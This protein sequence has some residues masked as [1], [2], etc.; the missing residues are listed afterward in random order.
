MKPR[1]CIIAAVALM[2]VFPLSALLAQENA[3]LAPEASVD[4]VGYFT[5]QVPATP[6]E[7]TGG[8]DEIARDEVAEPAAVETLPFVADVVPAVAE[9]EDSSDPEEFEV[10]RA[11]AQSDA[12]DF[13]ES[14]GV[15]ET[16]PIDSSDS[17]IEPPAEENADSQNVF[18][19]DREAPP[20][21]EN[22]QTA[23][24]KRSFW[25]R[26]FGSKA[27]KPAQEEPEAVVTDAAAEEQPED[28]EVVDAAEAEP[29]PQQI[30]AMQE[31]VRRQAAEIQAMRSFKQADQAMERDDYSVALTHLNMGMSVMPVRPQTL[32]IR[33]NARKKQ[34]DCAYRMALNYYKE[35]L[36]VEAKDSINRAN[37]YYPAD[38]RASKLGERIAREEAKQDPGV[39]PPK[40]VGKTD[41]FVGKH[42]RIKAAIKR[43]RQ[44]MEVKEYEKAK[45]E[46]R[47]VLA[48]DS[49]N[50]DAIANLKKISEWEY[51]V[52]TKM[53]EATEKD[54]ITQ[55]RA[56]WT[57]PL[58]QEIAPPQLEPEGTTIIPPRRRRL[59]DKLNSIVIPQLDFRQAN[60]VDVV[61]YLVQQSIAGDSKSALTERGVNLILN[62]KRPG[63]SETF[64]AAPARSANAD[65]FAEEAAPSAPLALGVPSVT[66]SL[67]NIL[68]VDAIK[69]ITEV[70]GL[71]Y[72][73]EDDVVVITPADVVVG[74]VITRTY[75]VQPTIQ[76]V[77]MSSAPSGEGAGF[78][79]LGAA[80]TTERADVKSFFVEAGVA[81]P[82]GTSIMYKQ[83]IN[84]LIVSNTEE[85][86]ERVEHILAMLDVIPTQ[87]EIEARFV[88]IGQK[89]LMELGVEWQLTDNWQI[90][91]EVG[92]GA[93]V[94]LSSRERIQVNKNDLGKGM[95]FLASD[96][97]G[98]QKGGDLSSI[99]SISSILTNPEMTFILHALE[100]K[101]GV[102]LLSAPKVTTKSGANAEIKVVKELIYPT[103]FNIETADVTSGYTGIT[104][105]YTVPGSFEV[106]DV[107]VMLNVTP[108]VSPDGYTIDLTM[109]PQ[110]VEL[111]EWMNYGYTRREA[112]G[113]EQTVAMP[114]PIFHSRTISTSISIWDGQTVVMGGLI[115][116]GQIT[117]EDKVPFL[118]D[119]PLIGYL[120]KTKTSQS[121]KRNLLIFVTARLV[122]PAGNKVQ[123]ATGG[124]ASR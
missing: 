88:E 87:V 82:A 86:L 84:L 36:V 91:Q 72:R 15:S 38:R 9:D 107:G 81:F 14:D 32:T 68:L 92:A 56:A 97:T 118:G 115:T 89:D 60:I 59:M 75:K 122:D 55:V 43:G 46:F 120:F 39:V 40:H 42:A 18:D 17:V 96:G 108:V 70:T 111:A 124:S 94:P 100:Q 109:Q 22:E 37:E 20:V 58:R 99:L 27:D 74:T 34:A 49:F 45:Y 119:L 65:P 64:E 16:L 21:R 114:Q 6:A 3:D 12:A 53:W 44:Y 103:E 112:D 66:L 102:N 13:S 57:P 71:K 47:S 63:E 76:D 93:P 29:S 10:D 78:L 117:T 110:V 23:E 50:E 28:A 19:I 31:E 83:N 24:P 79:D 80:S 25:G 41:E 95:R 106:R 77:F 69:Y 1:Y 2:S 67:R 54:M 104:P 123:T 51:D 116:E 73:I 26:L 5:E 33:E 105:T 30:M 7:V 48:E 4:E 35:G 62:L 11:P 101:S 61:Q 121:E 8:S 90:A 85:N 98:A 113:S 52:E